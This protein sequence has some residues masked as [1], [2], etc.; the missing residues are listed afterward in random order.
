V[1]AERV[2]QRVDVALDHS[3]EQLHHACDHRL[4]AI[5]GEHLAHP[6]REIARRRHRRPKDLRRSALR[7][8]PLS[9]LPHV[10]FYTQIT[11]ERP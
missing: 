9:L 8:N 4:G 2:A 10:A 1:L 11:R 3:I 6:G 5:L 7:R